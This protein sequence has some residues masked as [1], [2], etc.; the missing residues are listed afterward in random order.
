MRAVE[1]ATLTMMIGRRVLFYLA[2]EK[3]EQN[4]KCCVYILVKCSFKDYQFSPG[5]WS[6][7]NGCCHPKLGFELGSESRSVRSDVEVGV[8]ERNSAAEMF[9]CFY[10]PDLSSRN[11]CIHPP[12]NVTKI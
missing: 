3:W 10:S 9:S 5:M 4:Q 8:A 11:L 12:K 7:K 2:H 1:V 6:M